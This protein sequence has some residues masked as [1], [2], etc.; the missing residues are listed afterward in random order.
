MTKATKATK[1]TAKRTKAYS[2]FTMFSKAVPEHVGLSFSRSADTG[3]E[4]ASNCDKSC[5]LWNMCYASRIERIYRDLDAKLRRHYELGPVGVMV[6]AVADLK[7]RPIRW[8]RLS[9]DGSLPRL[10]TM[11]RETRTLFLRLLRQWLAAVK[12]LGAKV[13]IPV[14]SWP[15]AREYRRALKSSGIVVRRTDQ[16][17]TIEQCLESTDHRAFVVARAG[18]H[19]GCVNKAE[20]ADNIAY[21][22]ECAVKARDAGQTCVACPAISGTSLCGKCTACA[23]DLV[24]LVIYAFHG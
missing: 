21:A 6:R 11:K 12:V 20:K 23:D 13:H 17:D 8:A 5:K 16:S 2:V 19:S 1:A 22:R 18:I 14:E 9:V 7:P 24:D 10:R 4:G 3:D 15:K